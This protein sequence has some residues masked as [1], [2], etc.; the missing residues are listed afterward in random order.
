MATT[1]FA[2]ARVPSDHLAASE[3]K[4]P[5]CTMLI[6]NDRDHPGAGACI[7]DDGFTDE[8]LQILEDLFETL[9]VAPKSKPS[10]SN[11]RYFCDAA[12]K[13]GCYFSVRSAF[14]R[15]LSRFSQPASCEG[16][17]VVVRKALPHMRFLHY[18]YEGGSLP[19]HVDLS[20]TD[21]DGRTSTHT[22]ILYLRSCQSGG[23]TALLEC[24]PG[25]ELNA[26]EAFD[27]TLANV[28]PKRG[29]LLI[30][31]HRCPHAG[32]AVKSIP[33]ILLRG[34]MY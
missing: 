7:I 31:P 18:D 22:F 6:P 8:F 21:A 20:R 25:A 24:L 26:S 4:E 14:A 16:A 3:A 11:R 27:I 33:K 19:P 2:T 13:R 17:H 15:T 10:C 32:L 23:E 30:F 28:Q 12:G 5:V 34:E 29:R 1:F 9:P